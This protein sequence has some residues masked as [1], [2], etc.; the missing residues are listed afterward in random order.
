ML[1]WLQRHQYLALGAAALLLAAG[2]LVRDITKGE[3]PALVINDAPITGAGPVVV[4][5]AGAVA[6]PG[7]YELPA[8]ARVQDAVLAAGGATS[9][10]DVDSV[11]L[12]RHLRDGEKVTL[13][14]VNSTAAAAPPTLAPGQT[15]DINHASQSQLDGLPGIGEAYSRRIVDSRSVDGPYASVDDL[16]SRRVLPAATLA[17]VRDYLTVAP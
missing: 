15:L 17:T 2:L 8:G 7:V 11:N 9:G 12:A 16:V 6:A 14:S 10:A 3:P 13:P 5:V 1:A 4:H